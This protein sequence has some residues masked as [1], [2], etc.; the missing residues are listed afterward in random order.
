MNLFEKLPDNFFSILSSKNKNIYGIALV[1]LYDALTLYR[2]RIR[3]SDYLDLLKSCGEKEVTLFSFEDEGV[4]DDSPL[5]YEPSLSQK[6]NFVVRRL[7][8]TGWILIEQDV[9]TGTEYILLPTYSIS[10]LKIIYEFMNSNESQYVSYVHS[11]YSDLK[12]EDE[13]QDEFMY[14]TL[15]SAYNNTRTLEIEVAKLDHSIRVFHRQLSNIF[16]PNE[17][18][19]QHFDNCREDVVD[20]IY[21]PLKTSDSIIL[22]QGPITAILKRWLLTESVRNSLVEQALISQHSLKN[23]VEAEADV[24]KKINYIQDTYA[25]LTNEIGVI[26]KTQSD[27]IKA[28][29][30]KV[31]YLNN[32]DKSIR[33]K[34][35]SIFLAAAK[36]IAGEKKGTYPSIARDLTNSIYLYAQGFIDADSVAKPYRR[37]YREDTPPLELD[38]FEHERNEEFIG[39]LIASSSVY[40]E[41]AIMK[42]MKNAFNGEKE[43]K[44]EDVEVEGVRD[45]IMLILA[46]CKSNARSSFYNIEHPEVEDKKI[47]KKDEFGFP[48]LK[49]VKKEG[50]N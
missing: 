27:Y 43:L 8:E 38:T 30:E 5:F 24:I 18:L 39:S 45:Y 9:K 34:L 11:T 21:H 48:N 20:P 19:T 46:S 47:I 1:T 29:T 6:A 50:T 28:S 41:D 32:S 25:R 15:E 4:E 44:L 12:L 37:T 10:M 13:L 14:K 42:Y 49:Y 22:Y 17:V 26:D 3:K 35:E 16:S 2:N 40:S 36:T 31:I 33:G 7:M 23:K